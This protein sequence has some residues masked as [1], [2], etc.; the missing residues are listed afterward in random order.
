MLL[1]ACTALFA[2]G[3]A[4]AV[5][6]TGAFELDGNAVS[7]SGNTGT[8]PD[9]WDRVCH[10]VVGSDCGT[11]ANTNGATGVAWSDDR[12]VTA[13]CAGGDNCTVFTGGG[14]KDPADISSWNWK[15]DT[16][17]LPAKDNLQQGFSAR[18]SLPATNPATP[19]TNTCPNGTGLGSNPPVA[20]DSTKPCNVVYFGSTR[21]AN[22][23]DAQQGVWFLQNR[24]GLNP[25]G[26]FCAL[27]TTNACTGAGHHK[28][29]DVLIV[30]D[31][32]TGGATALI[33]VYK[34]VDSGGDITAN[35]Q[36]LGG[37][38]AGGTAECGATT[39]SIGDPFCGL[40]NSAAGTT[41]PWTFLDKS[42]NTSFDSGELYEAGIN[43]SLFPGLASECFAT[44]VDESRASAGNTSATSP[45]ATL[46]DLIIS[47]F[48]P[49]TSGIV[50]TPQFSTITKGQSN[51]DSA[52]VTGSGAG[53]PTGVVKFF[54]CDPTQTTNDA[55]GNPQCKSPNGTQVTSGPGG[56]NG[57]TLTPDPNDATKANATS[58]SVTANA[59]GTWCFRGQYLPA[60]DSQ[61][62]TSSDDTTTEC[63]NVVDVAI[64]T[65]QTYT[66]KDSATLTPSGPGATVGGSVRFRLYPNGA[67]SGTTTLV[68]QTVAVSSSTSAQTVETT[69]ATISAP[70][71]PTLSWLVEY[72]G[73][74]R[75]VTSSCA[76]EHAALTIS[77]G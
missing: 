47:S 58:G 32:S 55:N 74:P 2:I 11:T 71:Y 70:G 20:F 75:N 59:T 34:W 66:V 14:S 42:G 9:D 65:I 3:S 77:N 64:S 49:C 19:A 33:A 24:V 10:Q 68:D 52:V 6:D 5:H 12:T 30:S 72:S 13:E 76:T 62:K 18:Y 67:C 48:Q 37:T 44:V 40:V 35:I 38:P 31:F 17:G 45:F 15:T 1:I 54:I 21:V 36:S 27:D 51:T 16:G 50:T 28:A 39:P 60:A 53:T 4:Q 43:L 69:P 22:N 26:T 57:E 61:Y 46:K 56:V 63:F 7:S 23:G 29:G 8:K 41:S 73:T 25:D